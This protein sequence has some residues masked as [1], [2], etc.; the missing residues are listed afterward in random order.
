M[1]AT[2]GEQLKEAR[3]GRQISL[4]QA[5]E[6]TRVKLVYL[7]AL[8]NNDLSALPSRVQGKGFLRIYAGFLG[9]PLQPLLDLWDG[10][11]PAAPAAVREEPAAEPIQ[12]VLPPASQEP[13]S[14]PPAPRSEPISQPIP[15]PA[16]SAPPP[17]KAQDLFNAIGLQLAQRRQA[18]GLSLDEV[19]HHTKV[20]AANLLA[21]EEGRISD[22][23][24]PVQARGMLSNYAAFLDL[25]VD[26]VLLSF[27]EAL[28]VGRDER[29]PAQP[30]KGKGSRSPARPQVGW[31]RFLTPDLIIGGGVIVMLFVF[32][33]WT[34][35][36]INSQR[37]AEISPTAPSV[38]EAMLN[39]NEPTQVGTLI[40][41]AASIP[42]DLAAG[43]PTTAAGEPSVT[44][45][46][47][48]IGSGAIQIYL[49]AHQRSWVE[50]LADGKVIFNDRVIPGNAYTFAAKTELELRTGNAAGV[51]VFYNQTDLGIL[52]LPGQIK[53]LL[54][55][56]AGAITP[57]PRFTATPTPQ[58]TATQTPQPSPTQPTP[59]ITP[60]IP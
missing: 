23:P 32:A 38:A 42:G 37:L 12:A 24:S 2:I 8:E 13:V 28:Q 58:P 3:E 14:K 56:Q 30:A 39:T 22:L 18:L 44:P 43:N 45:T 19:E 6:T 10:K 34:A 5:A 26:A 31:R 47:P 29:L 55:N 35:S 52:G 50:I 40:S 7:Q 41:T 17:S 49:V 4:A 27:A 11:V 25:N 9:L 53:T 15:P 21:L 48:I 16:P 57:T 33:V 54:F 59:T 20:R 46:S 60:F 51:Q 36:R 1:T